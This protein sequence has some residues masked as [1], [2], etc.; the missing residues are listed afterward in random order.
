[1]QKLLD[2]NKGKLP[3]E[4]AVVGQETEST[5]AVSAPSPATGRVSDTSIAGPTKAALKAV[6]GELEELQAILRTGLQN[7]KKNP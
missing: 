4:I 7:V 3:S 5:T 1:M 2:Q 6:L